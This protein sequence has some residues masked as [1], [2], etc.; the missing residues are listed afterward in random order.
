MALIS[1][2]LHSLTEVLKDEYKTHRK[3]EWQNLQ[4][5]IRSKYT[6]DSDQ[7]MFNAVLNGTVID[8][9]LKVAAKKTPENDI[10]FF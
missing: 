10:E 8:E 3:E 4:N 2:A 5:T 9:A 7:D 1:Q 6:L